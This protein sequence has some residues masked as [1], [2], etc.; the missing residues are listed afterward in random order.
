MAID[1][2]SLGRPEHND[3]EEVRSGDRGNDKGKDQGARSLLDAAGEHGE[4][5]E[6]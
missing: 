4:L 6:L 5:G 3:G 2:E 1:I